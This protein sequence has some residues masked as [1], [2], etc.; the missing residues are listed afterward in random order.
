MIRLG[1]S[2][3]RSEYAEKICRYL[4]GLQISDLSVFTGH[5]RD[6]PEA[7]FWLTDEVFDDESN[8]IFMGTKEEADQLDWQGERIEPYLPG[9]QLHR[10]CVLCLN[11]LKNRS[12]GTGQDMVPFYE[13]FVSA[14]ETTQN[15]GQLIAVYSPI[16]GIG[17]TSFSIALAEHLATR[18]EK[19]RV[20]YW[21]VEGISGWKLFC[22]GEEKEDLSDL[23]YYILKEHPD[24]QA[25]AR[26]A[27]H[28][29]TKQPGGWFFMTPCPLIE[30]LEILEKEE[31]IEL[32]QVLRASFDHIV[33][34]MSTAYHRL[35]RNLLEEA[36]ICY[37]LSAS[38]EQDQAKWIDLMEAKAR[39]Q[40]SSIVRFQEI[41][42][43]RPGQKIRKAAQTC[44]LPYERNLLQDKDGKKR[45][46]T[47]T[48]W[49]QKVGQI[50]GDIFE[51]KDQI[52]G[53]EG[54]GAKLDSGSR[55][56]LRL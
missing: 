54:K 10:E 4:Q 22:F 18:N 26:M 12:T 43:L 7:D 40:S 47:T 9:R 27:H 53:P 55:R 6:E 52:C 30:D 31:L 5:P 41:R 24:Q 15:Q 45:L 19:E 32:V 29:A 3:K 8:F 49:Y 16:G 11:R 48:E 28:I 38:S 34:D 42:V 37:C 13:P 17:K 44:Y 51:R 35:N 46:K 23:L 25:A 39:Q 21:N 33:C 14:Q 1:I 56:I 20:L 36:D 50:A 2:L